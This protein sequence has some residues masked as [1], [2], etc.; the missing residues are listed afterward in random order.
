MVFFFFFTQM[1]AYE[2]RISDWSSDVCSSDLQGGGGARGVIRGE[3]ARVARGVPA[4]GKLPAPVLEQIFDH[5]RPVLFGAQH[6]LARCRLECIGIERSARL[7]A[8]APERRED[9]FVVCGRRVFGKQ[10]DR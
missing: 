2:M 4:I 3:V 7:D 6:A 10:I 9:S 8:D 5:R 1:T